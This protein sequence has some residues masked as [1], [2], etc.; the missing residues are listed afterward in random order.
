V[1]GLGGKLSIEAEEPLL[2]GREGLQ[3]VVSDKP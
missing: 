2:I 1:I 3:I